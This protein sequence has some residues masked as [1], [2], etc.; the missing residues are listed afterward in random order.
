[1]TLRQILFLAIIFVAAPCL[2]GSA[3]S[4][5]LKALSH[6]ADASETSMKAMKNWSGAATLSVSSEP[7]GG[8]SYLG[9][10]QISFVCDP[11][12]D[13]TKWSGEVQEQFEGVPADPRRTVGTL[14]HDKLYELQH[15]VADAPRPKYLSIK[16]TA[17]EP[18]PSLGVSRLYDQ[19]SPM[20]YYP[21]MN[22]NTSQSLR[23]YLEHANE[24]YLKDVNVSEENGTFLLQSVKDGV[25]NR[26]EFDAQH[27]Y[28]L[29]R[30]FFKDQSGEDECI[31]QYDVV[32]GVVVPTHY[33]ETMTRVGKAGKTYELFKIEVSFTTPTVN[34]TLKPGMFGL[35]VLEPQDGDM[36]DDRTLNSDYTYHP[37]TT[38][39]AVDD[40]PPK[41]SEETPKPS[42]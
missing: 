20:Q 18:L 31:A 26:Y 5:D 15:Y 9:V 14:W 29:K 10:T 17:R 24:Q 27:G 22:Q 38:T 2:A 37:P 11:Q 30:K 13:A 36:I 39:G 12:H 4:G 16:I 42:P 6:A 1:M 19:F 7:E 33:V 41:H 25:L 23:W 3:I 28:A 40:G 35:D 32:S 8:K 21:Q 34:A